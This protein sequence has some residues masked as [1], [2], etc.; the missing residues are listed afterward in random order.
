MS[1]SSLDRFASVVARRHP[2][3]DA[4]R[5][6]NV[7]NPMGFQRNPEL[8]GGFWGAPEPLEYLTR[9]YILKICV[10]GKKD[11]P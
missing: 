11:E 2:V 9:C 3:S 4:M 8:G 6:G 10:G 5:I 7:A 1:S